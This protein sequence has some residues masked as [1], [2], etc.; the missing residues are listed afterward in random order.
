M[1]NVEV[2]NHSHSGELGV[3]ASFSQ[4]GV[5]LPTA[6]LLWFSLATLINLISKHSRQLFLMKKLERKPTVSYWI[7]GARYLLRG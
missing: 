5:L 2:V 4:F 7:A 1:C 6:L 3:L